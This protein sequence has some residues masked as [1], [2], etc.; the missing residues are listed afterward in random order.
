MD[1]TGDGTGADAKL[2]NFFFTE[3]DEGPDGHLVALD[4]NARYVSAQGFGG[5]ASIGAQ[6]ELFSDA[7]EA[8]GLVTDLELGAL[9]QRSLSPAVA[10]G[11]RAGLIL[12]TGTADGFE[13]L[14]HLMTLL[15]TRPGDIALIGAD[16]TWLRLGASPTFQQG[17]LVARADVGVDLP[18]D[19]EGGTI[20]HLNLAAGFAKGGLGAGLELQNSWGLAD[21]FDGGDELFHAGTVSAHADIH[22]SASVYAALSTPLDDLRGEI[23]AFTVG[24]SAHD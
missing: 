7:E 19:S 6:R 13:P 24:V 2:A 15:A 11:L 8:Y 14:G 17:I 1:V 12:P 9:Y 5:Y 4:V 10:L 23:I 16:D 20:A 18:V 22:R 21:T 3:D